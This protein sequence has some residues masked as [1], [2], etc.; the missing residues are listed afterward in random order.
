MSASRPTGRVR[1][2]GASDLLDALLDGM[3]TALCAFD[4]TGAVTHWNREAERILGWS[5]AEA[6]GR[7]GLAGW[8]ARAADAAEVER[9]LLGAMEAPGRRVGEFA[10]LAKDGGRVLLRFQASGVR[11][12][13]GRPAGVYCAFS[14]V[15]TQIDLERSVA[16]SSA[17]FAEAA[18]GVV[19]VD[20]DLRP[21]VVNPYASRALGGDGDLLLGSPLG[22]LLAQGAEELEAALQFVLAEGAPPEPMDVWVT[23]RDVEDAPRRCWRSGFVRLATPLAEEPVP[24]GV[25]WFF[26]DVTAVR[27]Q[28]QET[29]LL[30]FRVNQ[31]HRAGRTAIECEDPLEAATVQV[32]F[33]LAGFADH[34]LVDMTG[35]D[36][37][38]LVRVAGTPDGAP[39]PCTPVAS[40]GVPVG[41]PEGHPA[42][43]ALERNGAVRAAAGT[44]DSLVPGA[45][46]CDRGW[47][48]D[49]VHALCVV[50]RSRGRALG[51]L[52]FLRG[53]G[54]TGFGRA[55]AAYA[56]DVAVRVAGA[57][58][59]AACLDASA[60]GR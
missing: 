57:L 58:D 41:Y 36:P 37:A 8:A 48:P 60:D 10:L 2:E 25:G 1:S 27:R 52:T 29:S 5:A 40:G 14:E 55:D 50:L 32:D 45:W 16:L 38:R 22:E 47:P 34:A 4:A 23:L 53:P 3:D 46:A 39:G 11:R 56:E 19:L 33:A 12:P 26:Q 15:H 31:L 7:P 9:R 43:Q 44:D 20:A 17:L 6:V 28:E 51:V 42:L 18:W 30:R 59:L 21:A 49:V 54:R 13:D 35:E 24:L